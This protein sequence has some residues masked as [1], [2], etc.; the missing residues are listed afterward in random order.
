MT[1]P[2]DPQKPTQKVDLEE[3]ARLTARSSPPPV[4]MRSFTSWLPAWVR[5]PTWLQGG[6][7]MSNTQVLAAGC[8]F[9]IS[10]EPLIVLAYLDIITLT[11]FKWLSAGIITFGFFKEFWYDAK[12]EVPHQTFQMNLQDFLGYCA[13]TAFAWLVVARHL[14][15][16]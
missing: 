16:L 6:A 9:L 14:G 15:W 13:G 7:W 10:S 2:P 5:L 3:L 8:H 11:T 1:P 4:P 12:Y